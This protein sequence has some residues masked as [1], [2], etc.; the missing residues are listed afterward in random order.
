MIFKA[1]F[2]NGQVVFEGD[3]VPPEGAEITITVQDSTTP[4][5]NGDEDPGPSLYDKLKPIIGIAE[6]LP[7]DASRNVDHY[8]YGHPKK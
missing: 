2:V 7:P 5:K 1:R 4:S 6:G 3:E 8:L